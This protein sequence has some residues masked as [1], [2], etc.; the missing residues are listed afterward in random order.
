VTTQNL[1][2][3][4]DDDPVNL[5]AISNILKSEYRLAIAKDGEQALQVAQRVKPDLILMDIVMPNVDGIDACELIKSD[6]E[7]VHIPVIFISSLEDPG[8]EAIGFAVGGCDYIVK[9]VVPEI[10][11]ARIKVH[12]RNCFYEGLLAQIISGDISDIGEVKT[13]AGKLLNNL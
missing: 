2:L 6:P 13:E 4:V 5:Q 1:I 3:V 12:L 11:R 8:D 9:P 7:L 10:L